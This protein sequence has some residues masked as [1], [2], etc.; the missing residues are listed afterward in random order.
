[1]QRPVAIT[2]LFLV[3]VAAFA[4]APAAAQSNNWTAEY[5]S[6]PSLIGPPTLIRTESTPSND[7]GAGSPAV[8]IPAD[9]FSA[10]WTTT[11]FL[12]AG[13]YQISV[14]ADDGVRVF[15][16][17]VAHID[18]WVPSPG[19]FHQAT[20]TLPAGN[21]TFVVEYFE[22]GGLAYIAY[23]FG[24]AT[25]QPPAGSPQATVTAYFLN[26]RA[27]P[28]PING[29]ILVRISRAQTFP[30]VGRNA[31][32]S[33][34]QLNV[35]GV[36]GWVNSRYVNAQ[37]IASVPITDGSTGTFPTPVPPP[38]PVGLTAT[39]TASFLNVRATPDP[40]NGA[41]LTRIT[42][43]QVFPVVGRNVD[44]SWLQL[45]VN[46]V[47]GWVNSRYVN[48]PNAALAPVT[49]P[50]GQPLPPQATATVTAYFLNVR[51]TPNP[52]SA[53][54]AIISRGQTFPLVG[55]NAAGTWVQLNVGGT[56]GWVNR[57][58]VAVSTLWNLPITG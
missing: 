30:V 12:N 20:V 45:N 4:A 8:N 58:W 36:I 51:S 37:N 17:G 33:W 47:I 52:T 23:N 56:I 29:A 39:V 43:G 18:H 31:N 42:N 35:N 50:G 7:W 11:A 6:N 32:F 24:Q 13:T 40:F 53:I 10:R 14:S 1:M 16:N 54:L 2:L 5:F 26:V 9:N 3:L 38:P 15:V 27:T 44:V 49:N 48:A 19:N 25:V 21:H 28:D 22:A 46:G 34:L 57:G 55:R 41:I